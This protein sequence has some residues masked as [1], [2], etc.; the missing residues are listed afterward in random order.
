VIPATSRTAAPNPLPSPGRF[1]CSFTVP[2]DR[3]SANSRCFRVTAQALSLID[4]TAV[5]DSIEPIY[6]ASTPSSRAPDR[7]GGIVS[8]V[9]DNVERTFP[10]GGL[11]ATM[12]AAPY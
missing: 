11:T 1:N 3:T 12:L 9:I 2:G 8:S 7:F 6:A 5:L 4:G 10:I